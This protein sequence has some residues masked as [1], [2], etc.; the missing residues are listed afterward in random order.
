MTLLTVLPIRHIRTN[1]GGLIEPML[2]RVM[3]ASSHIE[4]E[5]DR[6]PGRR[7]LR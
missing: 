7:A 5:T 3:S 4:L 6:G 2:I 1:R